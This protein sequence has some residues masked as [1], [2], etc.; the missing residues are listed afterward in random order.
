V[1]SRVE[2][3]DVFAYVDDCLAPV[4]RRAFEARLREDP[5]LRRQ[6]ARWE[7]QNRAIRAA[8]GARA[9][10]RAAIDLGA[11][12]NE[13]IP[14]WLASAL[15]ASRDVAAARASG[16]VAP[17]RQP[18]A[19][20]ASE[21]PAARA[22]PRF[23]SP[24]RLAALAAFAAGLLVVGPPG[25]MWPRDPL[26]DAGLAAY[27]AFALSNAP[28]EHAADDPD[29]LTKWLAPQ[30]VGGMAAPRFSSD[31]L[32]L[33]GGR[34]APGTRTRAAFLIY[35]DRRGERLGLLIEPI[36]APPVSTPVWRDVDG[37]SLAAWTGAGFAFVAAGPS[38]EPVAA[39]ARLIVERPA[40][41]R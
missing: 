35:E 37:A 39:L 32:R 16:E 23:L 9:P 11:G 28:V 21:G 6:V 4:E 29:A 24:R 17:T 33:I 8:Y 7:A 41:P 26:L 27:R 31:A 14:A 36:D 38:R 1:K 22:A 5:E 3:A 18:R 34:I 19:T 10:A 40:A 30:F 2:A 12:A 15:P 20:P 25:A 13:N